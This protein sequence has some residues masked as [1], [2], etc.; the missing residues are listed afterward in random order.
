MNGNDFFFFYCTTQGRGILSSNAHDHIFIHTNTHKHA[1]KAQSASSVFFPSL[2]LFFFFFFFFFFFLFFHF[3]ASATV[4]IIIGE[5]AGSSVARDQQRQSCL[6]TASLS[7][8]VRSQRWLDSNFSDNVLLAAKAFA[9]RSIVYPAGIVAAGA[10][11][12]LGP[13]GTSQCDRVVGIYPGLV[14]A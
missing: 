3:F 11:G 6:G 7:R 12:H 14:V 10:A 9:R 13:R 5:L 8:R 2:D 1:A 4:R